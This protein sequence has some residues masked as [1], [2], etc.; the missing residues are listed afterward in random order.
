MIHIRSLLRRKSTKIYFVAFLL[1]LSLLGTC[2]SFKKFYSN[3]LNKLYHESSYY[4]ISGIDINKIRDFSEVKNIEE[5]V[6]LDSINFDGSSYFFEQDNEFIIF[7]KGNINDDECTVSL[8]EFLVDNI[9]EVKN[10]LG[11]NLYLN[12]IG[13][14][15]KISSIEKSRFARMIVSESNFEKMKKDSEHNVYIVHLNNYESSV[16]FEKKVATLD[17]LWCKKTQV[18]INESEYTRYYSLLNIIGVVKLI[19]F[20]LFWSFLLVYVCLSYGF[21]LD[22]F[23]SLYIERIVGYSNFRII[24]IIICNKLLL[25]FLDVVF[26][27]VIY[28][29]VSLF[30]M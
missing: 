6:L 16:N 4:V 10:M 24:R 22:E 21:V 18:F 13:K 3:K 9:T 5:I 7:M 11:E 26:S 17:M 19:V 29:I 20:I 8:S 30:F 28:K 27:Y 12:E 23:R 25:D 2:L 1:L 14:I 15:L